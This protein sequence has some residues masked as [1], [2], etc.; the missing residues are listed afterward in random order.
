MYITLHLSGISRPTLREGKTDHVFTYT[1]HGHHYKTDTTSLASYVVAK[2]T[3]TVF[4]YTRFGR[5]QTDVTCV[6]SFVAAKQTSIF[7][8]THFWRHQ[9]DIT[10]VNSFVAAKQTSI[11]QYMF[12]CTHSGRHL[13]DI[14]YCLTS[15]V[16]AKQTMCS[17]TPF[18]DVARLA[19]TCLPSYYMWTKQTMY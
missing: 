7:T 10:C 12:T 18:L 5:H 1:S 11:Y 9:T 6:T 2:Q 19:I 14:T 16:V 8:Y 4:T 17:C 15:F 13:T 3:S